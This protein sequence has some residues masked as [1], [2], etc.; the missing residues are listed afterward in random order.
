MIAL[1]CSLFP[2]CS[3]LLTLLTVPESPIWL[4]DHNRYDEAKIIMKKFRGIPKN[5]Q[6]TPEVEAELKKSKRQE[7]NNQSFMKNLLK[8]SSLKPL[9]IM[10]LYFF[11]QQ[12]SGIFVIVY[13]AVNIVREAGVEIDGFIGAILIGLTRLIGSILVASASK[14]WGRR[15]PSIIS[16]TGMTMFMGILSIY[17]FIKNQGYVI[18]DYGIIP[19]ICILSYIFMSTIGF[20]C[21]PFA[22][23]GEIYPAKVKDV[24]S[25]LT[26]CI[27]YIF[28]FV[29][30][31]IYPSMLVLMGK[32]GVFCFYTIIS[33]LGTI[34]VILFLPETKGKSLQ[35][36]DEFY[37]KK[38]K[39]R[40]S[41]I[42][43]GKIS[44]K[45]KIISLK[46]FT[47]ITEKR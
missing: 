38:N 5:N 16:G 1:L 7:I 44:E 33:L 35:E 25:G 39:R 42:D 45:E 37:S 4:R 27:A 13:Y 10:L 28:S 36:I 24:L 43:D 22:M 34:F 26:T 21:L 14:K 40:Q 31:K 41:D 6:I 23:I 9:L 17:L 15:L 32:H 30:V 47:V 29:T 3:I 18:N 12:F 19:A 2:A 8:G 20:L 46:N 11:F